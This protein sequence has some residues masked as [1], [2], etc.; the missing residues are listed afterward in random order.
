MK[1]K[2]EKKPFLICLGGG[3]S[4]LPLIK[5]AKKKKFNLILIDKNK[6]CPGKKLAQ[7]FI[8]VSLDN[9]KTIIEEI[10]KIKIPHKLIVG[11]INRSSGRASLTMSKVQKKFRLNGSEPTM[12]QKILNKRLFIKKCVENNILVPKFYNKISKKEIS[13]IKFPLIVKPSE[14]VIGKKGISVVHKNTKI[15]KAINFAKKYSVNKQAIIQKKVFGKDIVLLGA[16][17]NRKY[18]DLALIDEI[19]LIKKNI[20]QRHGFRHPSEYI[21]KKI[22]KN[23]IFLA[24]KIIKLFK[25]NN[26][27]LNLSFRVDAQNK[28][29]L[30]EINLEISG[31]LIHEKLLKFKNSSSSTFEWYL[32]LLILNKNTLSPKKLIKKSIRVSDKI[33]NLKN[34]L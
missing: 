32:N 8:N 2:V 30:I 13:R 21:K 29:Y 16:V 11:V 27:P 25:L 10:Q 1:T 26:T 12:V 28:F 33:L 17:K 14:S 4:Q 7:F 6:Y 31:E 18:F 5:A 15:N 23:L 24:N 9:S 20:I 3:A 34:V 22:K 19:N